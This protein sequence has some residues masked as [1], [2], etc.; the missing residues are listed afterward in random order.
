FL[1]LRHN[2]T[3]GAD[4]SR[5]SVYVSSTQGW[6]LWPLSPTGRTSFARATRDPLDGVLHGCVT[7]VAFC[8]VHRAGA[9]GRRMQRNQM[10]ERE[11]VKTHT[12]QLPADATHGDRI[13]RS[14]TPRGLRLAG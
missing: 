6:P 1:S 3:R 12:G 14:D 9:R 7:T 13:G 4:G 10:N 2:A 8:H 11:W 5:G